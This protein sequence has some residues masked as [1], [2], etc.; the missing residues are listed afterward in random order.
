VDL[1]GKKYTPTFAQIKASDATGGARWRTSW[2]TPTRQLRQLDPTGLTH[3]LDLCGPAVTLNSKLA[4]ERSDLRGGLLQHR[5]FTY[6]Q[7]KA[8]LV[9]LGP[10]TSPAKKYAPSPSSSAAP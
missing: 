7:S 1:T 3:L 10:S 6:Y 8:S 2:S 5:G 9:T 4:L